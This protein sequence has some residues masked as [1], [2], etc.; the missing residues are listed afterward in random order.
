MRLFIILCLCSVSQA[1][2]PHPW[3]SGYDKWLQDHPVTTSDTSQKLY[4]NLIAFSGDRRAGH[5]QESPAP[6]STSPFPSVLGNWKLDLGMESASGL[7]RLLAI[8]GPGLSG[9]GL[10]LKP[11]GPRVLL[12]KRLAQGKRHTFHAAISYRAL[13]DRQD[14][15]NG[16]FTLNT[17]EIVS[18]PYAD[19]RL[20]MAEVDL[21]W[22]KRARETWRHALAFVGGAR[23][24]L[25]RADVTITGATAGLQTKTDWELSQTAAGPYLG[26]TGE[27]PVGADAHF[28]LDMKHGILFTNSRS[29]YYHSQGPPLRDIIADITDRHSSY[30]F[31][32]AKVQFSFFTGRNVRSSLGYNWSKHNLAK[33]AFI[34]TAPLENINIHGPSASINFLF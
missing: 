4:N 14:N 17:G 3:D 29:T 13:E 28:G 5:H 2:Q 1:G 12:E 6:A 30:T 33:V 18:I 19:N 8:Q 20:H 11:D 34:G 31:T 23:L 21:F 9:G 16:L 7:G 32:E 15:L 24:N 26:F 27:L 25:T 22:K 10:R